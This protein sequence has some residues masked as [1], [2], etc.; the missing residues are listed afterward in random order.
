ALIE[1]V[2]LSERRYFPANPKS[3]SDHL[4]RDAPALRQKGVVV[5]TG[6]H[7]RVNGE[8][9]RA[10]EV[11]SVNGNRPDE[12]GAECGT[13]G[14]NGTHEEA[15]APRHKPLENKGLNASGTHGTQDFSNLTPKDD[16]VA[17]TGNGDGV[18]FGANL[19]PVRPGSFNSNADEELKRDAAEK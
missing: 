3:L 19:R 14:T 5:K 9:K 15:G 2:P 8:H 4:R 6:L 13:H 7:Q 18:E 16:K 17:E 12:R 10:I 11:S 1:Y